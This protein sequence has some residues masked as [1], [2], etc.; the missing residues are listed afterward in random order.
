MQPRVQTVQRNRWSC[1]RV[2]RVT[3]KFAFEICIW[4]SDRCR[5]GRPPRRRGSSDCKQFSVITL[6]LFSIVQLFPARVRGSE[7]RFVPRI[8]CSTGSCGYI[9]WTSTRRRKSEIVEKFRG[10]E[11]V[12]ISR[13]L[14]LQ[15]RYCEVES[16]STEK[17]R[18]WLIYSGPCHRR[19]FNHS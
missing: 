17:F 3:V 4:Q 6:F 16:G 12:H 11:G 15:S 13:K 14:E 9:R 10:I 19:V 5:C 1:A 8:L 18:R 2:S 7:R